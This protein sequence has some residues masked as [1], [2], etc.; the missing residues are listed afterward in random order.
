VQRVLLMDQ[1][2]EAHEHLGK[3]IA[4]MTADP[5]YDEEQLRIYLGQVSSRVIL[6]PS[7]TTET[8]AARAIAPMVW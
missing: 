6:R 3:L 7:A 8:S 5:G 2:Q 4:E 1:L